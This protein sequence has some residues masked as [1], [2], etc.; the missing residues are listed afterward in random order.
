MKLKGLKID[1]EV[2]FVNELDIEKYGSVDEAVKSVH[3]PP[4]VVKPTAKGKKEETVIES[5]D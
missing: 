1:G 4:E 3:F 2:F 5:V